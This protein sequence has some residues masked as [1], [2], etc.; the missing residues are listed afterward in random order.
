TKKLKKLSSNLIY[1]K[2]ALKN[3]MLLLL[4]YGFASHIL[5]RY[6]WFLLFAFQGAIVDIVSKDSITNA[7]T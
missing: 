3:G 6:Y 7:K 2:N 5:F 4:F 1:I